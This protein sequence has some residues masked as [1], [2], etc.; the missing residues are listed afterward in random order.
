MHG[1]WAS[2]HVQIEEGAGGVASS[3]QARLVGIPPGCLRKGGGNAFSLDIAGE[4]R[5]LEDIVYEALAQCVW[6]IRGSLLGQE[7]VEARASI[8]S[9]VTAPLLREECER[10]AGVIKAAVVI[11]PVKR[12]WVRPLH[13]R[14]SQVLL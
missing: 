3:V 5:L 7:L 4:E 10:A 6:I 9:A 11:L 13:P 2:Q 8:P 14:R 1:R 12:K